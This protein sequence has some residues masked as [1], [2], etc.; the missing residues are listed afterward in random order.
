MGE[1]T[2][3]DVANSSTTS[4]YAGTTGMECSIPGYPSIACVMFRRY[5]RP[6]S[7]VGMSPSSRAAMMSHCR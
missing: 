7:V 3:P 1:F 4:L 6:P 5:S 2:V